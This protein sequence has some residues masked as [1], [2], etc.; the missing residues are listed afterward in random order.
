MNKEELP[1]RSQNL[2]I[3]RVGLGVNKDKNVGAENT[4][5]GF[6]SLRI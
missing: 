4:Y 1:K 6:V 5:E 3:Y 2:M